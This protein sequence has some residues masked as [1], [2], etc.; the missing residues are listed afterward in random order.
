MLSIAFLAYVAIAVVVAWFA[1]YREG[2]WSARIDAEKAIPAKLDEI[3]I[4]SVPYVTKTGHMFWTARDI[5]FSESRK[6]AA[7]DLRGFSVCSMCAGRKRIPTT[8]HRGTDCPLCS[9][10]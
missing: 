9:R 8:D 10:L 3:S 7:E 4:A 6:K 2:K 5:L 1:G